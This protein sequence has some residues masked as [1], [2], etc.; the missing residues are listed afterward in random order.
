M[1]MATK[2]QILDKVVCVSQEKGLNPFVLNPS[3]GK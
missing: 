3:M 2:V 1:E